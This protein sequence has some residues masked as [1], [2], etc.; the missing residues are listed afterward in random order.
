MNIELFKS[1]KSTRRLLK[2]LSAS[3]ILLASNNSVKAL[4]QKNH[5]Y[6]INDVEQLIDSRLKL[7][8]VVPSACGK[9]ILSNTNFFPGQPEV[10]DEIINPLIE[11]TNSSYKFKKQNNQLTTTGKFDFGYINVVDPTPDTNFI[12]YDSSTMQFTPSSECEI[13]F[14]KFPYQQD[15]LNY[16]EPLDFNGQVYSNNLFGIS[17]VENSPV[18]SPVIATPRQD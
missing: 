1:K 5:Q 2:V 13:R 16:T 10:T 18:N 11:P 12:N 9:L 8:K 17:T 4:A 15:R 7:T 6:S 14:V 3:L